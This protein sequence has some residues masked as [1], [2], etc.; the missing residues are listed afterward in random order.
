MV[1][2]SYSG[3]LGVGNGSYDGENGQYLHILTE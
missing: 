2:V 1:P 3:G